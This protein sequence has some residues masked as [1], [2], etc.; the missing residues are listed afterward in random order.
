M[1]GE[2]SLLKLESSKQ[3]AQLAPLAGKSFTV[4][5]VTA[6]TGGMSKWLALK[7]V[8]STAGSA[9]TMA[10]QVKAGQNIAALAGKSVTVGK[11]PII[12]GKNA[13]AWLALQ[14]HTATASSGLS[15]VG[16][17]AKGAV[18]LQAIPAAFT[19]AAPVA[20]MNGKAG[21]LAIVGQAGA[22]GGAASGA[23]GGGLLKGA[24]MLGITTLGPVLVIGS[25]ALLGAGIYLSKQDNEPELEI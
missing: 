7:P 9:N 13:G 6:G 19:K 10:V 16:A 17:A 3:L 18:S 11:S 1:A 4:G 24:G 22:A 2:L 5:K 20:I 21:A 8:A 23:T 25:L 14:N 15:S 12:V